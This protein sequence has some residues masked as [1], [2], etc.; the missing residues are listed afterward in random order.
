[1]RVETTH[2]IDS[3]E[4]DENGFYAWRYEYHLFHF[5]DGE[6]ELIARS[7]VDDLTSAQFLRI[8]RN[9]IASQLTTE[10][11]GLP[12]FN[13]AIIHLNTLGKQQLSWLSDT[14]Y[15]QL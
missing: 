15:A 2:H 1:M 7:Y 8:K 4:Q 14:G 9:G 12:V 10:D 11:L 6:V 13:D 5:L 3:S